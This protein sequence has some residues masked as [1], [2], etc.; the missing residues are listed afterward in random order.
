MDEAKRR[1]DQLLL[2]KIR[3]ENR[4]GVEKDLFDGIRLFQQVRSRV[5]DGIRDQF[6]GA[7]EDFVERELDRR[8]EIHRIIENR[9]WTKSKL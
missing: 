4:P 1:A 2:D 9:P 8:L 3:I 7:D 5:I 6:P